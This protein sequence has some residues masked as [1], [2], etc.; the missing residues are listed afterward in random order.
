[1]VVLG[2]G[3]GAQITSGVLGP[4]G[5]AQ[6]TNGVLGPE[7]GLNLA[8]CY[9]FTIETFTNRHLKANQIHRT[10]VLV[11]HNNIDIIIALW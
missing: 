6:I 2:P 7:G 1:M 11:H 3:V 9:A 8:H 4:G 5:G 10:H